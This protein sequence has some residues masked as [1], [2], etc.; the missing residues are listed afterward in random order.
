[1]NVDFF[2]S[3]L[4]ETQHLVGGDSA[5]QSFSIFCSFFVEGAGA[6]SFGSKRGG[7]RRISGGQSCFEVSMSFRF[8]GLHSEQFAPLFAL[9]DEELAEMGFVRMV[10]D[11]PTGFPC[12]IS[13]ADAAEGEELLLINYEHQTAHSPYRD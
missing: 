7:M 8:K 9:S 5:E 1:L 10:A 13:L 3:D 6:A 2:D 4:R 11:A 12:R